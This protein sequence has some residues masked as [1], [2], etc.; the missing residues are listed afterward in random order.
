V[1]KLRKDA[2]LRYVFTGEQK[3]RGAPRK[4]DGKVDLSDPSRFQFVKEVEPGV[5]LYSAVVWH[6]SLKRQIRIAYLLNS[7][8]PEKT[9]YVVLFSSD[10]DLSAEDIYRFYKSR[11]QIEFIFRDAKQFT[12]LSDCQARDA[13]KLDFHFNAALTTLNLAKFQAHQQHQGN[14][15][16]VFSMAS[17]KRRALNDYLLES[18][19]S[20]LELEP[21]SIKSHPNY[22]KLQSV[23]C[24]SP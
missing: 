15:P 22:Q 21:T 17:V 7:T 4:Y 3:K 6:V 2:D 18:F 20:M 5:K 14:A 11:F 13:K 19:I 12:G 23:G 16:F 9:S 24:I 1:G 10:I 8:K